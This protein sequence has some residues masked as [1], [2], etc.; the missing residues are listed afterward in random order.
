VNGVEEI[1]LDTSALAYISVTESTSICSFGGIYE[2]GSL[3]GFASF[4]TTLSATQAQEIYEQGV[5]GWLAA[6]P[7]YQWG[8]PLDIMAGWD[9][10]SGWAAS[11]STID[12]HDSFTTVAAGGVVKAIGTVVGQTYKL[13]VAVTTTSTLVQVW[14]TDTTSPTELLGTVSGGVLEIEYVAR[15]T[16]IYIRNTTAGVTDVTEISLIQ[17]GCL[18]HL[19]MDEGIGYQLH[20][21]ST[22]HHDAL[23]SETGCTH[24]Q[25]KREGFVRDFNVDAYNGG[26]APVELVS[27]SR[28]VLPTGAVLTGVM[29]HNVGGV[30]VDNFAVGKSDRLVPTTVATFSGN[31]TDSVFL[32]VGVN[33][34]WGSDANVAITSTDTDAT[35]LDI[36]VDYKLID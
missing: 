18:S 24:L 16:R 15:R 36:R 11:G 19:P 13:R 21:Q 32:P 27:S 25:P 2:K 26:G 28:D 20:D 4:N 14:E 8:I 30:D 31:F 5:S 22:N 34:Q 1:N 3:G 17:V 6:N 33:N 12:D 10:T 29:A 23:L 35:D 7:E 9:F